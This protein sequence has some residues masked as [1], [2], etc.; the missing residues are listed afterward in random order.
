MAL[1]LVQH[2][3]SRPKNEDPRQGLSSQ[4][5]AET[6]RIAQV[7]AQYE[8]RVACILHSGKDR[9]AQTAGIL[10]TALNPPHGIRRIEGIA[11]LDDV[12]S[13]AQGL[14][15][16]KDEMIVGHLPFLERLMAHLVTGRPEPP[17]FCMQNGGIVCLDYYPE[18]I[19][20]VICWALMP[21]VG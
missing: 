18:T 13:F 5:A 21:R 4:G 3:K 20:P 1:Y 19:Q 15:I 6:Q 2:G 10:A 9:A 11:P 14:D 8:V 12:P 7:A 16:A 17:V